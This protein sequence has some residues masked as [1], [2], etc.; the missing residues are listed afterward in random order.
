MEYHA[1]PPEERAKDANGNHLP[2]AYVSKEYVL[3]NM[4]ALLDLRNFKRPPEESGPFGK[5][6][7]VRYFPRAGPRPPASASRRENPNV[8]EFARLLQQQQ[9]IQRRDNLDENPQSDPKKASNEKVATECILYGYKNKDVEWKAIDKYER[10]S[11]GMI[12]EDYPRTDPNISLSMSHGSSA[13]VVIRTNL[14]PDANRKSKRYDGGLYWIKVTFDSAQSAEQAC[15][16]SPQEIDG[17]KVYCELYFGH[18]PKEDAPI[19]TAYTKARLSPSDKANQPETNP[20]AVANDATANPA[21]SNPNEVNYPILPTDTTRDP[22]TQSHT[23][24]EDRAGLG[25]THTQGAPP[26]TSPDGSELCQ[27]HLPR[28]GP[29]SRGRVREPEPPVKPQEPA[30][31]LGREGYSTIIPGARLATLHPVS[32]ALPPQPSLWDRLVR[33][34]PGF[35][36]FT[37]EVVGDGPVL[38][39]DGS[40]DYWNS[41]AY[42]RICYNIDQKLGTDL[43][44]LRD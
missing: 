18:G 9:E 31:S 24:F 38:K 20:P 5:K 28:P 33:S 7:T 10:I 35:G 29:F 41:N 30:P 17:Y 27:R 25:I 26:A 6:R 15:A 32:E 19:P 11:G 12:C 43:C 42:W 13:D 3:R 37:G 44:G 2:W 4:L 36:W 14:T 23:P 22:T 39:E 21:S 40:F 16:Y 34:I 8:L 1:V